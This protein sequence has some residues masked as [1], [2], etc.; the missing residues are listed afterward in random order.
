MAIEPRTQADKNKLERALSSLARE[1]PTFR[2]HLS[3][4]TG[5]LLINGM[6][7]LHLEII[8]DRLLREFNVE[9][10]VG[11]PRV[12]YKESIASPATV[13]ETFRQE[14]EGRGQFARVRI[15]FEPDR[16]AEG[17]KFYNE[18][19]GDVLPV[20]F[21]RAVER[22]LKESV[23]GPLF[24]FPLVHVKAILLEAAE[25]SFRRSLDANRPNFFD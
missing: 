2:T 6:G 7:E 24:G 21:A 19:P 12:S 13:E 9:A 14:V 8:R 3:T 4:Q 11:E 23:A 16:T 20:H 18:V 17:I 25:A 5:Q 22:T 1:D 15:L 10:N